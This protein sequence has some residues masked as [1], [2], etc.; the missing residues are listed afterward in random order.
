MPPGR[1]ELALRN[2]TCGDGGARDAETSDATGSEPG[3]PGTAVGPKL[4]GEAL[5]CGTSEKPNGAVD[6]C[7]PAGLDSK[8]TF[9]V[10]A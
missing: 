6:G 9:G 3:P 4:P 8:V 10:G 7:G 2:G 1:A 5:G